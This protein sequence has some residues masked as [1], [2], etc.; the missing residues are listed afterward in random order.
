MLIAG[1]LTAECASAGLTLDV[2]VPGHFLC[3]STRYLLIAGYGDRV[4]KPAEETS[5]AKDCVT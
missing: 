1:D 2:V 3:P 5:K 4:L